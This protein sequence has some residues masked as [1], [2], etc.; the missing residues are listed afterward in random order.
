MDI[1]DRIKE[2]MNSQRMSQ[3]DFAAKL[4]ITPGSLSGILNER[5][6]PTNNHTQAIHRAFPNVNISWLLFGE[7]EMYKNRS[8]ESMP[9]RSGEAGGGTEL[10]LFSPH[11][12][13]ARASANSGNAWKLETTDAP[14]PYPAVPPQPAEIKVVKRQIKEIRIFF[15]DGTYETFTSKE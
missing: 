7:G 5:T 10:S 15:D 14:R 12:D 2:L 11:D 6:K 1:K 3:Q 9:E 13:M 8:E 4:G